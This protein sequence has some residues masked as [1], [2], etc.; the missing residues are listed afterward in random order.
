MATNDHTLIW[1][2]F[3]H[4]DKPVMKLN[5]FHDKFRMLSE[6]QIEILAMVSADEHEKNAAMHWLEQQRSC[7]SSTLISD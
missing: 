5:E 3:Q 1:E 4:K 2:A 6:N 7:I